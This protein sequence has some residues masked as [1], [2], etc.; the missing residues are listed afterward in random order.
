MSE[1][2]VATSAF[3]EYVLMKNNVGYSHESESE[4]QSFVWDYIVKQAMM[5]ET[6]EMW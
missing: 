1:F 5:K 4:K 6:L 3:H 2:A